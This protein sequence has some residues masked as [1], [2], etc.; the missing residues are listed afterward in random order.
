MIAHRSLTDRWKVQLLAFL[1]GVATWCLCSYPPRKGGHV[2][3]PLLAG[4]PSFPQQAGLCAATTRSLRR[5]QRLRTAGD[6]KLIVDELWSKFGL[7]FNSCCYVLGPSFHHFCS[8][9]LNS[10]RFV[11]SLHLSRGPGIRS[12]L[13]FRLWSF[14]PCPL[15]AW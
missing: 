11:G 15:A 7:E 13:A 2:W 14:I 10:V 12:N 4:P 8:P 1:I 3:S 5:P 9:P 6:W